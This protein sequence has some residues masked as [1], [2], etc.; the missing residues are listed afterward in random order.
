[1]LWPLLTFG[2]IWGNSAALQE[3]AS[4]ILGFL[5]TENGH[6]GGPRPVSPSA[7]DA[8]HRTQPKPELNNLGSA[9][10]SISNPKVSTRR[11]S[12]GDAL[13][14]GRS[15]ASKTA[16]E[17]PADDFS[18]SRPVC[19]NGKSLGVFVAADETLVSSFLCKAA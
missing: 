2:A 4:D 3:E 1:M 19:S 18:G 14:A 8:S 13:P 10:P 16:H 12:Q 6:G 7:F 15:R 5:P 9:S 17:F 11:G